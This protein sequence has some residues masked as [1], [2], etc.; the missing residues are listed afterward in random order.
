MGRVENERKKNH[1]V[2]QNYSQKISTNRSR[3]VIDDYL[4][5][6]D[7]SKFEFLQRVFQRLT[8]LNSKTTAP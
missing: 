7:Y 4:P 6:G 3:L 8:A 5:L 2:I 1:V